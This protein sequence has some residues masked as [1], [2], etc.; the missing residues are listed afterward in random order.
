MPLVVL[1]DLLGFINLDGTRVGFL[2]CNSDLGQ[3][4][5]DH[6]TLYLE[7]ACQVI[8]SDFL[9]LHPPCFPPTICSVP[10]YAVIESSP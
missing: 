3:E 6:L 10:V 5:E 7:L 2:L 4:I 8:N 1:L 9:L